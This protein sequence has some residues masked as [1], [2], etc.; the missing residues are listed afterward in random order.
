MKYNA[1]IIMIAIVAVLGKYISTISTISTSSSTIIESY[2]APKCRRRWDWPFVA[3]Y[4]GIMFP[5]RGR[6]LQPVETR[7]FGTCECNNQ[8]GVHINQCQIG[9][10]VCTTRGCICASGPLGGCGMHSGAICAPSQ[11]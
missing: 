1:I 9:V 6:R 3:M 11:Q 2:N 7:G 5:L 10:P 8:N 4:R